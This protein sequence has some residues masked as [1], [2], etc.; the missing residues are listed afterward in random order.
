MKSSKAT[1]RPKRHELTNRLKKAIVGGQ[2]TFG[3]KLPPIQAFSEMLGTNYVTLSRALHDLE[4]EGFIECRNGVGNFVKYLPADQ[5]APCKKVQMVIERS[6]YKNDRQITEAIVECGQVI[7]PQH[8]WDYTVCPI[9]KDSQELQLTLNNPEAFSVIYGFQP[10]LGGIAANLD[11]VRKRIVLLGELANESH[12][13]TVIA[14]ES[15]MIK[16]AVEHLFEQGY[17]SPCLVL[18]SLKSPVENIF[19][20]AFHSYFLH[21]G[22]TIAWCTAHCHSLNIDTPEAYQ[23]NEIAACLIR[24]LKCEKQLND[25]DSFICPGGF[26]AS[27]IGNELKAAGFSIPGDYGLLSLGDD[28][29]N[30]QFSP[31]LTCI[32]NNPEEHIRFSAE[33]LDALFMG[34]EIDASLFCVSPSLIVRE[35]SLRKN[36][37]VSK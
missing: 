9:T 37:S 28:E 33:I 2:Y 32:D 24:K 36:V 25:I 14:D 34:H 17:T 20:E 27:H 11:F 13:N 8:G 4:S 15:M 12:I 21:H 3:E 30:L 1:S 7:F 26:W 23:P 29:E 6:S 16:L 5:P 31:T 18:C 35:S 10:Y 19:A 22:K